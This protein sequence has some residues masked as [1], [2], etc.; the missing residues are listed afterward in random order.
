MKLDLRKAAAWMK[1]QGAVSGTADGWSIDTRTLAPGDVYFALR[2]PVHDGHDF[3]AQAFER[4]AVC[5]VVDRDLPADGPLLRV[6]N[7]VFALGQLARQARREWRGDVVAVTGSAGKTT[8]KDVIARFLAV[9]HNVG[10]TIGNFNNHIGVPLSILRLPDDARIGVLELGMNHAGE[11]RELA[12]IAAPRVGVVTNVGYAH[13]EFFQSID[14]VAAAK[15]ELI[16][17]LPVSG[18]AILNADDERVARFAAIHVG[19]SITYGLNAGA[20]VRAENVEYLPDGARFQCAGATFTIPLSGRHGI[21][22]V[23][24]GIA[25]ARVFGLKPADLVQAARTIPIGKMRGERLEHNGITIINDA[26]NANPEAMRSMLD[27]L[28]ATPARRR[29]AVLGEMLEL[30]A[31]SEAL[32]RSVGKHAAEVKVGLLIGIQGSARAM[33]DE[34]TRAGMAYRSTLFFPDSAAAGAALKTLLQPGDAV[35]FKGSRGVGVERAVEKLL[36]ADA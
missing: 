17:A 24:A 36:E 31:Q 30:G 1:A 12:G 26:Y 2:G 20:N 21:Q 35:L 34:A 28:A 19:N 33:L 4:G 32:H 16:E 10:K 6:S 14:G 8:T 29:V 27:V 22:N 7:S 11:I 25:A 23:L 15:R 5:A 9:R 3:L 13:V 18:T